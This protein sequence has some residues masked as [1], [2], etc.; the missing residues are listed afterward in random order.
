LKTPKTKSAKNKCSR[1][2]AVEEAT[3][4]AIQDIASKLVRKLDWKVPNEFVPEIVKQGTINY[5]ENIS[6]IKK[7]EQDSE[8]A[9]K[10]F[11]L[12]KALSMETRFLLRHI[13]FDSAA[14]IKCLKII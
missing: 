4:F 10:V 9:I 13:V 2:T 7:T 5:P 8:R 6:K 11:A 12:G 1:N 14:T 3:K